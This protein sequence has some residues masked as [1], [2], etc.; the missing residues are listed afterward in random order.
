MRQENSLS[1]GWCVNCH[2]DTEADGVDGKPVHP[3]LD[4]SACHY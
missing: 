1:M 4:C 3:S 2:R